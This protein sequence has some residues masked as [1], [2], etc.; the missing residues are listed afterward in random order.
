MSEQWKA[1]SGGGRG[2]KGLAVVGPRARDVLRALAPDFPVENEDFPFL[3]VCGGRVAGLP[4]RV[5]RISFSGELGYEI[6]VP[7]SHATA[8]WNAVRRAGDPFGLMPYG[9]EALDVLRIEKGH[10]SVGTEIDGRTTADDLGLGRLISRNKPF[11][12]QALLDRPALTAD[13]RLQLVGLLANDGRTPIPPA[14]QLVAAGLGEDL[15]DPVPSLGH[16]TASIESPN[17]NRPIA[18]ALVRDGRAR[19]GQDLI[20]LSPLTDERVAVTVAE[21]V[22]YDPEGARLRA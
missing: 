10:L 7:A 9:L 18:L 15:D 12:G 20:A 16:V 13:G 19:L 22:F 4:A 2:G 14:A 5:F 17:L 3:A 1:T 21:P 6:N 8:L 11:I